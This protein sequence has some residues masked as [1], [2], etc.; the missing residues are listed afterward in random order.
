LNQLA[1]KAGTLTTLEPSKKDMKGGYV[2]TGSV[3]TD[4]SEGFNDLM[5]AAAAFNANV[6]VTGCVPSTE[7]DKVRNER[8]TTAC[9]LL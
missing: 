4:S 8:A 9:R 7:K 1:S 5:H 2:V 3:G 6:P